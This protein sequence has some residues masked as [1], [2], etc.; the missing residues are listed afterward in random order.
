MPHKDSKCT[1]RLKLSV[2]CISAYIESCVVSDKWLIDYKKKSDPAYAH[3]DW[4]S[5]AA[6][7]DIL[8][9]PA[10]IPFSLLCREFCLQFILYN[11]TL[12]KLAGLGR[13]AVIS[14]LSVDE[15]QV[16]RQAMLLEK[17]PS[18]EVWR[19]WD[20]LKTEALGLRSQEQ[21][22]QGRLAE[23]WTINREIALI[24]SFSKVLPEW[25]SLE[26]DRYGFDIQSY[27]QNSEGAITPIQIEVKSYQNA[28][29]PQFFVTRHEWQTATK[30]FNS[31]RFCVWCIETKTFCE[32]SVKQLEAHVPDDRGKGSWQSI[33]ISELELP[34]S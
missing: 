31:Y 24:Q 33:L 23:S 4:K 13:D 17:I 10:D 3:L 34:I 1:L 9:V 12:L 32:Y 21:I 30:F 25:V 19:W 14:N 7:R 26:S 15:T 6:W 22:E 27:R 18:E 5:V 29:Q 2:S 28:Q 11:K 20:Q 8:T 16:F